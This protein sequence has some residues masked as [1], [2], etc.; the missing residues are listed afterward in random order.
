L[1][2]AFLI[3]A[4]SGLRSQSTA[5]E[6]RQAAEI[7]VCRSSSG[8]KEQ[9]L[10]PPEFVLFVNDPRLTTDQYRRY[11]EGRIRETQNFSDCRPF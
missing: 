6:K 4:P 11:L 9:P 10:T 2:P 3:V 8:K 5:D 7:V 1:G